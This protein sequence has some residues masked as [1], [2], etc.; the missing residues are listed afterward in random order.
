[1]HPL[2]LLFLLAITAGV[3]AQD[4]GGSGG[5]SGGDTTINEPIP[6][7]GD[8]ST[9]KP[10]NA[11]KSAANEVLRAPVVVLLSST[12]AWMTLE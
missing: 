5:S 11:T 6:S 3:Q 8:P 10:K 9:S 2:H 7:G 12:L 4:D 1:M